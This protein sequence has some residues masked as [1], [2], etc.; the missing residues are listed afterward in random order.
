LFFKIKDSKQINNRDFNFI[1]KYPS[2]D[3]TEGYFFDQ[4]WGK[5]MHL[6]VRDFYTSA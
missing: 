1:Q 5:Q 4:L 6:G 2:D 3:F